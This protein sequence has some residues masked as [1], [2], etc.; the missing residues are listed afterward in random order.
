MEEY[1]LTGIS[2]FDVVAVF[3]RRNLYDPR[4]VA[5]GFRYFGFGHGKPFS[6]VTLHILICFLPLPSALIEHPRRWF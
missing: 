3:D 1:A 2:E 5:L 6:C 4:V